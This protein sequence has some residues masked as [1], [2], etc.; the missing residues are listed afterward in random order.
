MNYTIRQGDTFERISRR[1]FGT[2][3]KANLIRQVNPGVSEPL[4]PGGVIFLPASNRKIKNN[5]RVETANEDEV[6]IEVDGSRFRYWVDASIIREIDT[7][8]TLR[9]YAAFDTNNVELRERFK[10]FSYI[11]VSAYIGGETL[12]NGTSIGVKPTVNDNEKSLNV[13]AYS[14][15]GAIMDCTMPADA[16]TREFE[17]QTLKGV[18]S[19]VCAPFGIAVEFEGSPGPAFGRVAIREDEKIF[20]FLSKLAAQQNFIIG[21]TETGGLVF[22]RPVEPGNPVARLVQSEAPLLEVTPQFSEQRFYSHIT[23][24]KPAVFGWALGK[25]YTFENPHLQGVFRPF[26]FT[27]QDAQDGDLKTAVLSKAGRMLGNAVQYKAVVSTFRDPQGEL[28]RPNTTVTVTAPDAM[29]YNE[30]EFIVK[31]VSFDRPEKRKTAEL[32]LVLPGAYSGTIPE[33]MPWD[34]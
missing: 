14:A 5:A 4:V 12:F 9:F 16:Q 32:T 11:D 7:L 31:R 6:S 8:D 27:V 13:S 1:Q 34:E 28:W 22:R 19:S 17:N 20:R 30:F 10:P 3:E 23:G 24:L 26:T 25:P 18:A 2:A 21:S 33:A 29:V 15:A